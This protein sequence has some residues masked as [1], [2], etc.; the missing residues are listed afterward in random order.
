MRCGCLPINHDDGQDE[1][2]GLVERGQDLVFCDD[3]RCGAFDTAFDFD[4]AQFAGAG[5]ARFD[6][7]A[8]FVG[9]DIAWHVAQVALGLHDS[10]HG[11][12]FDTGGFV[13]KLGDGRGFVLFL[14]PR[15]FVE[16]ALWD[17]QDAADDDG[18]QG[19]EFALLLQFGQASFQAG[20]QFFGTLAG[21]LRVQA[22]VGF[23]GSL[24]RLEIGGAVVPVADLFGQAVIDGG[25]GFVDLLF[26]PL[27]NLGE[28]ARHQLR[29]G[30]GAC[31]LFQVAVEPGGGA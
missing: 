30:V 22:G 8:A 9:A 24:L 15:K 21:Y 2:V 20:Q 4:E 29:D 19:R 11:E 10:L 6:V 16:Q 3:H 25:D 28:V 23:T 1:V 12:A 14:W 7:V 18:R 17:D 13:G 26:A 5:D 31:L 27:S